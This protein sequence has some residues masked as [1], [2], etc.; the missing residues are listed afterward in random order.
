MASAKKSPKKAN[1]AWGLRKGDLP[2]AFLIRREPRL[3]NLE[4][5]AAFRLIYLHRH[6]MGDFDRY[7]AWFLP[8]ALLAG[9]V[10][11]I[12]VPNVGLTS[13]FLLLVLSVAGVSMLSGY[14]NYR[15]GSGAFLEGLRR[16]K[17]KSAGL[18][19]LL[20][21]DKALVGDLHLAGC[22]PEEVAA[23]F[24]GSAVSARAIRSMVLTLGGSAILCSILLARPAGVSIGARWIAALDLG[25]MAGYGAVVLFAPCHTLPG[26]LGELTLARIAWQAARAP[27]KAFGIFLKFWF[28]SAALG[29]GAVLYAAALGLGAFAFTMDKTTGTPN[30]SFA[31]TIALIAVVGGGLFGLLRGMYVFVHRRRYFDS[32]VEHTGLM[33][34]DP[35]GEPP[36]K[37]GKLR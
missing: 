23:A 32:M 18:S 8:I 31:P 26:K 28:R 5:N 30:E 22:K 11:F 29:I 35:M 10:G 20:G 34:T 2:P 16:R 4:N 19:P 13:P 27:G 25:L 21:G 24:L 7:L 1:S 9:G 12:V 14:R 37:V 3:A 33:L 17:T 6:R 36:D 15:R